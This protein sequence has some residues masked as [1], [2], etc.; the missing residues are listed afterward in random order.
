MEFWRDTGLH[1]AS[2]TCERAEL[3]TRFMYLIRQP[4][5]ILAR[6][7]FPLCLALLSVLLTDQHP[8]YPAIELLTVFSRKLDFLAGRHKPANPFQTQLFCVV[9]ADVHYPA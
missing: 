9:H 5:V 3:D 4:I 1:K 6:N 2:F 8:L 7:R